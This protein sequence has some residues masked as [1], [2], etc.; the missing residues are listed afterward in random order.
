VGVK[1]G[2]RPEVDKNPSLSHN[3]SKVQDRAGEKRTGKTGGTVDGREASK[4]G[5]SQGRFEESDTSGTVLARTGYVGNLNLN[6]FAKFRLSPLSG[7][8]KYR[9][10]RVPLPVRHRSFLSPS[11]D[12]I[13][14]KKEK[15]QK[16]THT[17]H[18]G[19]KK[20]EKKHYKNTV[21]TGYPGET[22]TDE[23]TGGCNACKKRKVG[24]GAFHCRGGECF[25]VESKGRGDTHNTPKKKK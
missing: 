10:S 12:R 22:Q 7:D 8:A 13:P 2:R 3:L 24:G 1:N 16:I 20:K 6:G 18:L 14:L 11:A 5:K 19:E 9:R 15:S 4:G 23:K 17:R 25:W 21:A